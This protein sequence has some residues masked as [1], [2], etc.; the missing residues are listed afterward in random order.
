MFNKLVSIII[1]ISLSFNSFTQEHT[2]YQPISIKF[3]SVSL[4]SALNLLESQIDV[5]FTYNSDYAQSKELIDAIFTQTPL[6]IVLD[7]LFSN[8][9]LTY[10]LIDKQL[11]IYWKEAEKRNKILSE[12]AEP[13]IE[14]SY[15]LSGLLI[16]SKTK[17]EI[18]FASIGI[19]NHTLGTIAN[20][21][22]RFSL[23]YSEGN[24]NDTL[25][26][27][28]LG[29]SRLSILLT[30][31][32]PDSIYELVQQSI[33]LQEVVIR[34]VDPRSLIKQALEHKLDNYNVNPFIHRA[35][36][37]EIVK[38]GKKFMVYTEGIFD[39]FRTAYRPTLFNDQV[40]LIK[41]R[42][43][44]NISSKDTVLIKLH[45][46]LS[47]SLRLDV[48]KNPVSFINMESIDDYNYFMRNIVTI[49]DELVY[50]IEFK[51]KSAN[52]EM[53]FEGEVYLEISNL[54]IVQVNFRYSRQSIK[55]LKKSFI[56]R[57]SR[58][59]KAHPIE[60]EYSVSYKKHQGLY[61]INHIK[62]YLKLRVRKKR[63]LLSS[64]YKT[65]FEMI[66][67]DLNTENVSRFDR[68]ETIRKSNI[69][70]DLNT[71]YSSRYWGNNNF[72]IPEDDL[73]KAL[74]RFKLEELILEK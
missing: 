14:M 18:P 44:T 39:I 36:Y 17:N 54:A 40:K 20:N 53:M 46:G 67:T 62:G 33:S 69:F 9:F 65:S 11:V 57:Q 51:Q 24:L 66:S 41:Q 43:F 1:L 71:L 19:L 5:N 23:T 10:K 37:R 47:A 38:R 45:G 42:K 68:G 30:G 8:P 32:N 3:P 72:I 12:K 55:A 49:N 61:Y 35:F 29:Y 22:G 21:D 64:V 4:D 6:S 15:T 31:N 60:A 59:I 26:F 63:E 7:S 28:H 70:S 56:I 52:D 58:S 16:D 13:A 25:V 50:E 74:S 48:I 73:G 2:L 27:N 34:S